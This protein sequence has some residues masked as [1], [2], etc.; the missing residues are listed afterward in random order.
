MTRVNLNVCGC[1]EALRL[2]AE[3]ARLNGVIQGMREGLAINQLRQPGAEQTSARC[4]A[5][6]GRHGI[7]CELPYGHLGE[8][9]CAQIRW[10]Q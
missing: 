1:D 9:R 7:A 2:R 5:H 10:P 6:A 3:V 8:H 4:N